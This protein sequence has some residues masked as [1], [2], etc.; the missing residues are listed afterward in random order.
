[1]KFKVFTLHYR[2]YQVSAR[3]KAEVINLAPKEL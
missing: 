1:M 2:Y 3:R